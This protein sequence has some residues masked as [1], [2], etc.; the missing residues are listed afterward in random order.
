MQA[1]DPEHRFCPHPCLAN[2]LTLLLAGLPI[3]SSAQLGVSPSQTSAFLQE[4]R[5]R[6]PQLAESSRDVL[7]EDRRHLEAGRALS[8][9]DFFSTSTAGARR[10]VMDVTTYASQYQTGRT[11]LSPWYDGWQSPA[12]AGE[13]EFE[14]MG[15]GVE[16]RF[17]YNTQVNATFHP[18]YIPVVAPPL[19]VPS[20]PPS[21][22]KSTDRISSTYFLT[23]QQWSLTDNH[24]LS[25]S[26]GLGVNLLFDYVEW[27]HNHLARDLGL[28]ILPGSTLAY[29]TDLG[30][31][32]LTV[33]A[34][35]AMRTDLWVPVWQNS[36]GSGLTWQVLDNLNWTLNYTRSRSRFQDTQASKFEIEGDQESDQNTISSQV[37]WQWSPVYALGLEAAY[38]EHEPKKSVIPNRNDATAW[39][40]GV[41]IDIHPARDTH[42]RLAGGWQELKFR[43]RG[44]RTFGI[45]PPLLLNRPDQ[46]SSLP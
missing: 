6:S 28:N 29:D 9:P 22:D 20:F 8:R 26:A 40:L 31:V 3:L 41:F 32:H 42:L 11:Y 16:Q 27:G 39:N 18:Q 21:F 35:S 36:L 4:L 10:L 23:D 25:L 44:L 2:L 15:L 24:R 46:N 14:P 1:T 13:G 7:G 34:T 17:E 5:S 45:F 38:T 19:F 43:G 12:S 30:P 37:T 33:Y